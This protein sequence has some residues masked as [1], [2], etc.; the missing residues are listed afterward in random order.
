LWVNHPPTQDHSKGER[1]GGCVE[2][3]TVEYLRQKYS[4][5]RKSDCRVRN[6]E[7]EVGVESRSNVGHIKRTESA[8]R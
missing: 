1:G 5:G 2:G 7:K 6:I 4:K 3:K 8:T